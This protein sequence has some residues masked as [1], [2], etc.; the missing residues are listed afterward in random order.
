M[1]STP[2]TTEDKQSSSLREWFLSLSRGERTV[3]VGLALVFVVSIT[4]IA[5]IVLAD[6]PRGLWIVFALIA[7][8]S[9]VAFNVLFDLPAN[10]KRGLNAGA[11]L[12]TA[13]A[14]VLAVFADDS[15][16]ADTG[17]GTTPPPSTSSPSPEPASPTPTSPNPTPTT[18]PSPSPTPQ[19]TPTVTVRRS[20]DKYPLILPSN[21]YADLDS[22]NRRWDIEY[23]GTDDSDIGF[24]GY[25]KAAGLTAGKNSGITSVSGSANYN[26]CSFETG[27]ADQVMPVKRGTKLCVKTSDERFAL[28]T[29]EKLLSDEVGNVEKIQLAV[30]VWE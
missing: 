10:W 14:T 25:Y 13:I 11:L 18:S 28:I 20:T 2:T 30:V 4:C 21:R 9:V 29:V 23:N 5:G 8:G 26:K 27:Y 7:A 3:A 24:D 12:V 17:A 15:S 16:P 19:P 6:R 1:S 22:R